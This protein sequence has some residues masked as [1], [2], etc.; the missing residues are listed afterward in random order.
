MTDALVRYRRIIERNDDMGLVRGARSLARK[1]ADVL[2]LVFF[3]E[4]IIAVLW[5]MGVLF[6]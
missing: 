1:M 2:L 5:T 4:L 6:S 3:A